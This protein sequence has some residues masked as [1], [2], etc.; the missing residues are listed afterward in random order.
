MLVYPVGV[1]LNQEMTNDSKIILQKTRRNGH[2]FSGVLLA[3]L[4]KEGFFVCLAV[5]M[6]LN[7]LIAECTTYD[8][9]VMMEEKKSRVG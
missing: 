9:K 2:N 8:F 4:Q 6:E 3:F 5:K 1:N 7:S